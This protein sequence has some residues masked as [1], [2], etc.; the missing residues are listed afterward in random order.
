MTRL[1]QILHVLHS[2]AL[3]ASPLAV[4][5]D[6]SGGLRITLQLSEGQTFLSVGRKNQHPSFQELDTVFR[7]YP[8]AK[9]RNYHPRKIRD[10]QPDGL[11]HIM[12]NWENSAAQPLE[13]IPAQLS[14]AQ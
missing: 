8:S 10:V 2:R 13:T 14:F 5:K 7:Y 12:T 11:F 4:S 1:S 9:P 3:A 6:L